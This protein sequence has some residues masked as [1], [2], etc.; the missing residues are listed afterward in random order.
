[1]THFTPHRNNRHYYSE[2]VEMKRS[3][4]SI[5]KH[6][7]H[8]LFPHRHRV[9]VTSRL[10]S[11]PDC[12]SPRTSRIS[13]MAS[14]D[15]ANDLK[16]H[17]TQIKYPSKTKPRPRQHFITL[18][19]T[20]VIRDMAWQSDAYTISTSLQVQQPPSVVA[21]ASNNTRAHTH[22]SLCD[23]RPCQCQLDVRLSS[24]HSTAQHST[25]QQCTCTVQCARQCNVL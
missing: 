2:N 5:S 16:P 25:A 24:A 8:F 21:S 12:N 9:S 4:Y 22:T 18:C 14:W 1:M 3:I 19:A 17:M 7:K 13:A 15:A 23:R 10:S 20:H 11:Q 6:I